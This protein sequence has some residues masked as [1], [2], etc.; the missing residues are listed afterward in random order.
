MI[1]NCTIFCILITFIWFSISNIDT[2]Y[3][4]STTIKA[5]TKVFQKIGWIDN[6]QFS[7]GEL[8]QQMLLGGY[9]AGYIFTQVPGKYLNGLTYN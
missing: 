8:Q 5:V 2:I 7:W 6:K 9:W 3:P 4:S 1:T